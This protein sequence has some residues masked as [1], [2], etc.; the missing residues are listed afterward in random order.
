MTELPGTYIPKLQ[1]IELQITALYGV[2]FVLCCIP[3][4]DLV[5]L[6]SAIDK[7]YIY[8]SPLLMRGVFH[9][10]S[11]GKESVSYAGDRGWVPVLGG[12]PGDPLQYSCLENSMDRGAWW[13]TVH[14]VTKRQT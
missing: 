11:D 6:G 8:L 13:A 1:G 10:S 9:G 14:R 7:A 12:S 5:P 3:A 4:L 2:V